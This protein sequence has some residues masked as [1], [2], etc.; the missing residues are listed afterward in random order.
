MK[1]TPPT[2][3]YLLTVLRAARGLTAA[4]AVAL[5]VSRSTVFRWVRALGLRPELAALRVE[6]SQPGPTSA[7]APDRPRR[8]WTAE[9]RTRFE[10]RARRERTSPCTPLDPKE[11]VSA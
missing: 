7:Q 11:H 9:R 8:R 1:P 4:A 2:R 5:G 6:Y 3:E 10:R